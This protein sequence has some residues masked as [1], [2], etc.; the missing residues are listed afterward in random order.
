MFRAILTTFILMVP[1]YYIYKPPSLLI[2]YFAHRW[3]DVLFHVP[4][5]KKIVALTIDDAPSAHT[6]EILHLLQT[7]NATATFF[8]IGSQIP[9][10]EPVLSDLVRAGCELGNHAMYDEPSRSLGDD[11]LADQIQ[12][13]H[14]K[15]AEAYAAADLEDEIVAEP[16][17]VST[18]AWRR[19]SA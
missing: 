17:G 9:G 16:I 10:Y 15:I 11:L 7:H 3:P 5:T 18:G 14:V 4:T 8:V 6:P 13:V 12:D 1:L 2:R 19:V